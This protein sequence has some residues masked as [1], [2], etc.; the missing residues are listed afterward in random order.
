MP[1]PRE[2]R[3]HPRVPCHLRAVLYHDGKVH[4][5]VVLDYSECGLYV[6]SAAKVREG[7][8]L[9]L[10]FRRPADSAVVQVQGMVARVVA[11]VSG[12]T[13]GFGAQLFELMS[14]LPIEAGLPDVFP[15]EIPQN[16]LYCAEVSFDSED[17]PPL[18][19]R[20]SRF[21]RQ[22]AASYTLAE[23]G[24][25]P[26]FSE[27]LNVSRKG[28]FLKTPEAI[29]PGTRLLLELEGRDVDGESMP[30]RMEVAVVW[31]GRRVAVDETSRGLGCRLLGTLD[32]HGWT[33]WGA[34]LRSLLV[35]GNPMFR[36]TSD[37]E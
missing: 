16:G 1:S 27:V 21:V 19:A 25:T 37:D 32:R 28:L 12:Q 5:G 17:R 6:S 7:D 9:L 20:E 31:H 36:A 3:S 22:I 29:A 26:R 11:E 2:R 18:R 13:E 8:T 4:Q 35:V 34:L 15:A 23:G 33:R 14:T 24:G 10:R 30:L